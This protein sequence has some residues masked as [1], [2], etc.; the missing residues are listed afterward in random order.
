MS[1]SFRLRET[2]FSLVFRRTSARSEP[3]CPLPPMMTSRTRQ[4]SFVLW[5]PAR[6]G[7]VPN[8]GSAPNL[9]S[10]VWFSSPPT[11]PASECCETPDRRRH[12]KPRHGSFEP[13]LPR[14]LPLLLL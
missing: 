14:F 9:D 13:S 8:R 6:V 7:V 12:G 2:T 1:S 10:R 5:R 4:H 3:S 11:D